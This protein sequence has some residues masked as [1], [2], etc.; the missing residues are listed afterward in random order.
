MRACSSARTEFSLG[1]SLTPYAS[2]TVDMYIGT[3]D[4]FRGGSGPSAYAAA[5]VCEVDPPSA[6]TPAHVVR[7]EARHVSKIR[8]RIATQV[9]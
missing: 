6:P 5:H 8:D 3:Q 4:F 2:P 1:G 9:F 7:S